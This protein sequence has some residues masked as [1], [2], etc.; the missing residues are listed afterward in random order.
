MEHG[1]TA[2]FNKKAEKAN[3]E[4]VL[5]TQDHTNGMLGQSFLEIARCQ[6]FKIPPSVPIMAAHH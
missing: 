3:V 2:I 1:I 6:I 5:L 4:L